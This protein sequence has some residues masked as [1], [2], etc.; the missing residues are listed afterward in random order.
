MLESY[1]K[2]MDKVL[3][4]KVTM[5]TLLPDLNFPQKFVEET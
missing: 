2:N 5:N 3:Y 1:D 4:F